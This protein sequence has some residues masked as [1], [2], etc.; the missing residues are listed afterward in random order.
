MM[1]PHD[2]T[3]YHLNIINGQDVYDKTHIQ[4]VYWQGSVSTSYASKG[5][6]KVNAV[7][8]ITSPQNARTYQSAW[9]VAVGDKIIQGDG[10]DITSVKEL[11]SY[12][13]VQS[14]TNNNCGSSVDNVVIACA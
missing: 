5:N 9:T 1:F 4:G 8:I 2:I 7:T 12:V 3:I 6:D 11:S 14:V 13:T 10:Q